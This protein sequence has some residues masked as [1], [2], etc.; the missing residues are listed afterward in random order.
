MKRPDL[1]TANK[2]ELIE[3]IKW[4]SSILDT[5]GD[6]KL[7]IVGTISAIAKELE[8]VNIGKMEELP[9]LKSDDKLFEKINI[10]IKSKSDWI[11]SATL[12]ETEE[13]KATTKKKITKIQDIVLN[14]KSK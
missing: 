14:G 7:A 3:Y 6:I 5:A 12:V 2:N 11:T 8:L 9:I 10:I 4:A 13:I 1:T